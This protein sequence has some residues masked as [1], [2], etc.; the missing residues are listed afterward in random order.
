VRRVTL[1]G[2]RTR[3]LRLALTAM[4]IVL[5]VTFVTGTLVLGDTLNRTFNNLIGT[6]YQHVSFEIRGNAA[7]SNGGAAAVSS[8]DNR[9]PVPESIAAVVARLPGVAYVNGNVEGYAQFMARDGNAVGGGGAST[10]GF[11]F[12]P[13]RQLSPYRLVQGSAPAGPDDVVMDKA[14]ATKDHFTVGERVLINL[15]NRPR[16]FTITGIVTFGSDNNLAGIT[17]AGFSLPTAQALFNTRG[18]FDTISVLAKPGAD[19][20]A[21][22]RAITAILPPGVQVISGQALVNELS[23]AVDSQLSFISTALLIFAFIALFVGGFTIFNTFS[24]TIGQRTRELALLRIVG[25]SRR[26]VF[27]SVLE[28]AAVTGLVGSVIGLGLGVLAALGLKALLSAFGIDL[29][30]SPLVFELRT[31]VVAIG[32]GVGVTVIASILPARRA[33]RIPPVT[34]LVDQG[35]DT[36]S[37]PRRSRVLGGIAAAGVGVIA[38]VAGLT[39]PTIGLVGLGAVAVFLATAMLVPVVA[40]PLSSALGRP[41]AGI[42]GTPGR[43]ARENAMRNPLRTAQTSA[44]LMIGLALVSTIAVLGASL[45]ASV[46]HSVDSAINADYIISGNGPF[47]RSAVAAISHVPGVS[48]ATT[49]YQ[50]QFEFR[51]SL[52]TLTAV[53]T[54]RLTQ[55]IDLHVLAGRGAPALAAGEL[56]IDST[57]ARSHN[58]HVGSIVP[59]RFARTGSTTMRVGGIFTPNPLAGSFFAGDSF[60]RAHFDNPLPI[61]VLLRTAPGTPNINPALNR[62]LDPYANVSAKTRAQFE[63]DQKHQV[64]QLL[65]L[66]YVLLALAVVIALIGIVNTLVLSVLERTHE[67]GLLRAVGMQRRQVKSMIRS[68]AV[69]IALFGAIVGIV[70]GTALG[71]ALASALRNHSVTTIAV[72]ISSLIAF[73]ILSALLG[74]AAAGW[75]ARR[76]AKLDVLA[77]IAAD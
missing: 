4:A 8:S 43:L 20:V 47:S 40:R 5:G 1:Q 72:P 33:V 68:E 57:A 19:T 26:Q 32:V 18:H 41:L 52:S 74:L 3:K 49:A 34:A 59:V 37:T 61:I 55:T 75:P 14:T 65:G 77:A 76:A 35:E 70:I 36:A 73:L 7:F 17:L 60:F 11:S 67:I 16:R 28:E 48:T 30:S 54:P 25:A 66:V 42:T 38:I 69:I 31:P 10:L 22:Q 44:A 12:D 53:S 2:L 56:L 9:R 58:L 63:S 15:P 29:P 71:V 27:R 39:G 45:T 46:T 62:I 23:S 13:D 51:G 24:I 50:G 21:L 64:D 6:A